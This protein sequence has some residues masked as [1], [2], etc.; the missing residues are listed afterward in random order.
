MRVR[1]AAAMLVWCPALLGA[2]VPDSARTDSARRDS[3]RRTTLPTMT[4]KER[5]GLSERDR[6]LERARSLGG[7]MISPKAIA[8]AAPTS[9]T[10]GDL[11]R[12]TAGAM[13][14]VVAG[15]GASSCLLVQRM[16][17]LQQQQTCALLVVDEVVSNGDAFVA[18]TDVELIVVIPASAATVRFGERGRYGAVAIY[19]RAGH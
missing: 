11:V 18:P 16:A 10:L 5:R 3:V 17:N 2:Q 14:Q 8:A 7:R 15:Y 13:V 19:T 12:R 9:R 6:R 1:I 4:V